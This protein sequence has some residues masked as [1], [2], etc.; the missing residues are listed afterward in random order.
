MSGLAAS[1]IYT[2]GGTVVEGQ[3]QPG[4]DFIGHDQIV[5]NLGWQP[6]PFTLPHQPDL[7]HLRQ[8]YLHYLQEAYRHLDFRGLPQ[9]ERIAQQLPLD[10]VYVPLRARPTLPK[11]ETWLRVG[12]RSWTLE[13]WTEE[14]SAGQ[15]RAAVFTADPILTSAAPIFADEA[16][17]HS[18]ALVILGDPGAGKS[19]LLKVLTLALARQNQGPLPILLPLNAYAAALERQPLNLRDFLGQYFG[20]RQNRL[21]GVV[22]LFDVALQAGQ[23]LVLLDGLD[24]VQTQRAFLV[25]LIQD[26]AAEYVPD[27]DDNKRSVPGNRLIV[28]SRIVGYR[29][30]PLVGSRW[31]TFTLEDFGREEITHFAERWTFA[32]EK[33]VHGETE[34][35]QQTAAQE[36]TELLEA[37]FAHPGVERLAS[38]PLLLTILALIKRQGV[39]LP[40]RRVNLYELYLKTLVSAWNKARS[41][42][43]RQVGPEMED[44]LETMQILAALALWLRETYPVASL[45]HH[46]DLMVWLTGYYQREWALPAG[47]AQRQARIFL[48]TVH[49][50]SN[51]LVERGEKQYGFLHLTFEEMLAAKGIVALNPERALEILL[52]HVGEAHWR[53]TILLTVGTLGVVAQQPLLAGELLCHLCESHLDGESRGQNIL[54]AGEAVLDVGY[55]AVGRRAAARV[56]QALVAMLQSLNFPLPTRRQAGL[57]LGRMEWLPEDMD[58]FV[59]VC[60]PDMNKPPS[61]HPVRYWIGKYPVTNAQYARF[62]EAGGYTRQTL[63]RERGWAWRTGEH[64]LPLHTQTEHLAPAWWDES[65]WNNP[66]SPVV[67]VTCYEAVAYCRWLEEQLHRTNLTIKAWQAKQ[68]ALT[69]V[70]LQTVRVRLPTDLEWTW[71]VSDDSSEPH[72]DPNRANTWESMLEGTTAVCMYPEGATRTGIWDTV[73]NVWEWSDSLLPDATERHVIV[74]GS[75]QDDCR[76]TGRITRCGAFPSEARQALGFRVLLEETL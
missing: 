12:G 6:T 20:T 59:Q 19:T 25:Q 7:E 60:P 67:G 1:T 21:Q 14:Q 38:N 71:I 41:L 26:F 51:I 70:Q 10:A 36:C 49:R 35:A 9:V 5:I 22:A 72:F 50:H 63:W 47:P 4:R 48:D 45:V 13:A 18:P 16:L 52:R 11:G 27:L 23:A 55:A 64:G 57:L 69:D 3:V 17:N 53:E 44:D 37:I 74:G 65:L 40:R 42:D 56:I 62:V 2:S 75:W 73:G 24:E 54:L 46:T 32:F 29:E 34:L 33:T 58:A 15:E 76:F 28:T 31:Q 68:G 43:R 8:S 30:A 39:T 66:L 61:A